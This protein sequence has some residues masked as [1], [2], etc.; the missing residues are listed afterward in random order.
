MF[1]H[2]LLKHGMELGLA[3]FNVC[4]N[5][6]SHMC[7]YMYIAVLNLLVLFCDALDYSWT[8][9][10]FSFT[11]SAVGVLEECGMGSL[12]LMSEQVPPSSLRDRLPGKPSPREW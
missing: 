7:T 10:R 3:V 11:F 4:D 12:Q 6:N 1:V 2:T 5:D 8:M 9:Y